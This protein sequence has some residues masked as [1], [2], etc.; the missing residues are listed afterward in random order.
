VNG[1]SPDLRRAG[2][3]GPDLRPIE[4]TGGGGPWGGV[5]SRRGVA[6]RRNGHT[7]G[8]S[9]SMPAVRFPVHSGGGRRR[10]STG[11]GI[12]LEESRRQ[13]QVP[14]GT[15]L[16]RSPAC[17]LGQSTPET[18]EFRD[19]RFIVRANGQ[20]PLKRRQ[21][22]MIGRRHARRDEPLGEKRPPAAEDTKDQ[23]FQPDGIRGASTPRTATP[24]A[25]SR[26]ARVPVAN[27]LRRSWSIRRA[28]NAQIRVTARNPFDLAR[29]TKSR[30]RD[31][32]KRQGS[33]R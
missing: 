17:G 15:S 22:V 6:G 21:F 2:D 24:T 1:R 13:R 28:Q 12:K 18:E 5:V 20:A 25:A 27:K 9:A 32:M 31:L 14:R 10:I 4:I 19:L 3:A 29:P 33:T 26:V 8:P 7:G 16:L 23:K 11:V 30:L